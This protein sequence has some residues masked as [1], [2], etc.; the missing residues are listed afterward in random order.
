M[1][2]YTLPPNRI[3]CRFDRLQEPIYTAY[4][5]LIRFTCLT[6]LRETV[7][8]QAKVVCVSCDRKRIVKT[9]DHI[10]SL[11]LTNTIVTDALA[12]DQIC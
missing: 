4:R 7:T 9:Y 10:A 2:V 5:I 6:L 3:G 1:L 12:P 8:L 11:S